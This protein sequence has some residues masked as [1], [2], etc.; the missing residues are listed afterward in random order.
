MYILAHKPDQEIWTESQ[1]DSHYDKDDSI[2]VR[3]KFVVPARYRE[4]YAVD[5]L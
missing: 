4:A 3:A 5:R 2:P 1:D